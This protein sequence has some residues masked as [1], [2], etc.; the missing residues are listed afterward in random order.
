[1]DCT[2]WIFLQLHAK[3]LRIWSGSTSVKPEKIGQYIYS[4]YVYVARS[5]IGLGT[6]AFGLDYG[7]D[8]NSRVSRKEVQTLVSCA[9]DL[10]IRVIDTA[11]L[12][13]ESENAL[14]NS[15]LVEF[16]LVTKTPF[17]DLAK[18]STI[19]SQLI[20]SF[21]LS[22]N[23]LGLSKVYGLLVHRPEDLIGPLGVAIWDALREL[24][25][26]QKVEAIG[27][28][29][30]SI[31]ELKYCLDKFQGIQ[32]VQA[33]LNVL[34]QRILMDPVVDEIRA[35]P[36]I[37]LHVRS[38]FLQGLL[39][40]EVDQL[41]GR[42]AECIPSVEKLDRICFQL[43]CCRKQLLLMFALNNP[44]VD[45]C[46]VGVRSVLELREAVEVEDMEILD[47]D[48]PQFA[49]NNNTILDPFRWE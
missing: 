16:N 39:L 9:A 29:V 5:R 43:G 17:F 49:I 12:Y 3:N 36:S 22:L 23:R 13:G 30:T 41:K 1:M 35:N 4:E 24:Q 25:S 47:I 10:G 28:S 27:V 46:L 14:G 19:K 18:K 7:I 40:R 44:Y 8:K 31:E 37:E 42:F 32:I 34:D 15:N 20:N 33:P 6:A 2:P 21:K 26:R 38:V 45:C 11:H 48:W